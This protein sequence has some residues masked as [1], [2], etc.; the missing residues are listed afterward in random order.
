MEKDRIKLNKGWELHQVGTT[1]TDWLA[2]RKMP[3]QVADIL[4]DHEILTE[5]VKLGW[6]Q[7]AQWISDYEWEYRCCFE[8]PK[9]KRSRLI[10]KGLDTLATIYLNGK[11]IGSHDDFYLPDSIELHTFKKLILNGIIHTFGHGIILGV[12]TLGHTYAYFAVLQTGCVG[13]AGILYTTI[14]MMD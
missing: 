5:E 8:R 14:G 10:F 7:E 6:C 9:G 3:S 4:L 11:E 12:S 2:I 13:I 1:E